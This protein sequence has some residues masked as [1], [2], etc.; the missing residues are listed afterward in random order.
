[1]RL[2]LLLLLLGAE[3]QAR[4]IID[5]TG[6]YE[7]KTSE[8]RL[9]RPN[10]ASPTVVNCGEPLPDRG[11]NGGE[12]QVTCQ[13]DCG[14]RS[15]EGPQA[16]YKLVIS[17]PGTC[18]MPPCKGSSSCMQLSFAGCTTVVTTPSNRIICSGS[19]ACSIIKTPYTNNGIP[20]DGG[21]GGDCYVECAD[22]ACSSFTVAGR[23]R[24][25]LIEL[26]SRSTKSIKVV[27]LDA[28]NPP[29]CGVPSCSGGHDCSSLDLSQCGS[30]FDDAPGVAQR[31]VGTGACSFSKK[32]VC[33]GVTDS[34]CCCEPA[35]A[36]S[37]VD[38]TCAP[39]T[40][41]PTGSPV[42]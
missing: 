29:A 25:H 38:V 8:D 10:T 19:S 39:N 40:C 24:V 41:S 23:G 17:S 4:P 37:S 33:N 5:C 18:T 21:V 16:C 2:L 27:P 35:T 12:D 42:S 13:G 1:M 14:P 7:F 36:C 31:C 28:N 9:G 11:S 26:D 6:T 30:W 20:C 32:V 15:C 22:G 3:G 34:T